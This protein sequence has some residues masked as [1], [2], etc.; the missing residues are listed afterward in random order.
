MN[1]PAM[2]TRG[3]LLVG[4]AYL[5]ALAAAWATILFCPIDD[6]LYRTLAADC[7]ATLVIFGWSVAYDNSSFYDA[8]WSVIPIAII[9]YWISQ[10]E[11][12]VPTFRTGAIA[13]IISVWG[14]RLTFNWARG[15]SGL[16]HEDWRYVDFRTRAPRFY[17]AISLGG[18][19]FY[20]TFIVFAGLAAAFPAVVQIGRPLGPIDFLAVGVGLAGIGFEWLADRQL[21]A[22]VSGERKPGETL[23]KGLW[24]Y[25]RHPNYLGE[26]LIWWSLYLFG[27]A[28][29]PDWARWAI[30]APLAM[31]AMFLFVSIPL[32]EKRS[33]ERRTDYP[34]VID[35]T[36][37]LIPL[38]PR[39]S[40]RT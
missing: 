11:A 39:R 37:M 18:F 12:G 4:L 2:R 38:P 5:L 31:C 13:M 17:W 29:D 21:H 36:S 9:G 26:M 19:H 27:L 35:E 25:S 23:R 16:E 8:F 40:R 14:A 15:W 7:V 22:F 30:L 34:Q 24:R 33:L 20:P 10:A 32:I 1:T 28:A 3:L 6:L